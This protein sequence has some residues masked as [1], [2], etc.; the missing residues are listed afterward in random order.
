M[1]SFFAL[2]LDYHFALYEQIGAEAA[3]Q[4][5][6]LIDQGHGFLPLEAQ[7]QFA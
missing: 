6:A 1:E 3:L 7:A 2:N 4:L 5:Y